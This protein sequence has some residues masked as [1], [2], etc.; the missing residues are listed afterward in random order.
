MKRRFAAAL[1]LCSLL[2][3]VATCVVW[4]RNHFVRDIVGFGRAGGNCPVVQSILGR[5]HVLSSLD[6]GC[7]RGVPYSSDRLV[8]HATWNGGMSSYP[9]PI[10]RPL[11]DRKSVG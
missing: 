7:E 3:S 10:R 9:P 4:V 5:V 6:G 11:G 2:L 8:K 1:A